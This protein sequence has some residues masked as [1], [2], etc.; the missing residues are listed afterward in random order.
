MK[1]NQKRIKICGITRPEDALAAENLGAFAVGFVFYKGSTRYIKPEKAGKISDKLGPDILRT[2]VFVNEP[3]ENIL[4][5]V[6]DAGLTAIQLHG[7]ESPDTIKYPENIPVIKAFRIDEKFDS[8]YLKD[9][10]VTAF[11]LDT[12]VTGS[13][14]GGTGRIFDWNKA[15]ECKKYG[16]IILAGGLNE[17]N[18]FNA[19][20]KVDPWA[21]DVSSG[22][23]ISPGIKDINKMEAFFHAANKENSN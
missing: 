14:F 6:K 5:I 18:V 3:P 7:S 10:E 19:L 21:L 8:S 15:L 12:Y 20:K 13:C 22:V 2:G 23:E 16:K 11:L 17:D 9:Y 1:L 4:K